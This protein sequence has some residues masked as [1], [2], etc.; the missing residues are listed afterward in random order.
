MLHFGPSHN[1]WRW[2]EFLLPLLPC[3]TGWRVSRWS[4]FVILNFKAG[5]KLP[6][7]LSPRKHHRRVLVEEGWDEEF[8]THA[9]Q[10]PSHELH[11]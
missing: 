3:P 11:G 9:H 8:R 5:V 1:C 10:D 2:R 7:N 4:Q 6:A